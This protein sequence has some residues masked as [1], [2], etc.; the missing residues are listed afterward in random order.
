MAKQRIGFIG[1]GVM[2]APMCRNL[3]RRLA[4]SLATDSA[5][6]TLEGYSI[7]AFDLDH[8]RLQSAVEAGASAAQSIAALA[9]GSDIVMMSLPG[10]PEVESVLCDKDGVFNNAL[11][12][13]LIIDF[14]TTPVT[15]TQQL[16]AE[17]AKQG[18]RY[19]DSPVARTREAAENGTLAMM[20]GGTLADFE[21][22]SAILSCMASDVLHTGDIGCGQ[23]AKILNNMVL[24]QTVAA[25]AEAQTMAN[26]A[27]MSTERLFDALAQG[28]ANSFALAQHG[29]KSMQ[30]GEF[31]LQA[32]SVEYARKDL[33]Y[34]RQLAADTGT[35]ASGADNVDHLF[36][37]AIDS[38]WGE[39]YW[40]VI[41]KLLQK[42][43]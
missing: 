18:L 19:L 34:A 38:G 3:C 37:Q 41:L 6:S 1:L 29:R 8:D 17:A 12:G 40:P 9:A 31:P 7:S 26:R 14:S 35:T 16:A 27:G 5:A 13:A 20:V 39:Q 25:L 15:L 24:F 32:F 30:P 23:M 22:A 2:G 4:E 10:G 11:P 36:G 43:G 21:S 42:S 28:S 33:S